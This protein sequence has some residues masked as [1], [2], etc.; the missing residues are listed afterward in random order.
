MKFLNKNFIRFAQISVTKCLQV[1]VWRKYEI[2]IKDYN[3]P[4]HI[5]LSIQSNSIH[6]TVSTTDTESDRNA[7]I[8]IKYVFQRKTEK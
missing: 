7:Q 1:S 2:I 4:Q 8:H 6:I 3:A 5:H